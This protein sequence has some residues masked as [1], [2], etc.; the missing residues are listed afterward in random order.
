MLPPMGG[1]IHGAIEHRRQCLGGPWCAEMLQG[2]HIKRSNNMHT[3]AM[4]MEVMIVMAL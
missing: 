2:A 3:S 1:A 4:A